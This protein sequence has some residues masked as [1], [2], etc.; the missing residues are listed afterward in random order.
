MVSAVVSASFTDKSAVW[1]RGKAILILSSVVLAAILVSMPLLVMP[2]V[3]TVNFIC[4]HEPL[5]TNITFTLPVKVDMTNGLSSNEAV[6]IANKV[7]DFDGINRHELN[8][9]VTAA[10]G[11]WIVNL[12][13]GGLG[14][15]LSHVFEAEIY[16]SNQTVSFSHCK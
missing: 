15:E 16:P 12:S 4:Y 8:S 13:W 6:I 7:A 10:D 2:K 3:E 14:E 9:A 1:N 5:E 11:A